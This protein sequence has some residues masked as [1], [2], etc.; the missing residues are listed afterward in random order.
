MPP[1]S[2]TGWT[3]PSL[4]PA[5]EGA[6]AM[7]KPHFRDMVEPGAPFGAEVRPPPGADDWERLAAFTG[8]DPRASFGR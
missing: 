6:R 1:D 8:R 2:S 7:I 5:L 3:P 4:L